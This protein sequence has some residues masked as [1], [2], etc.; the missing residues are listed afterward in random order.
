VTS[1]LGRRSVLSTLN[2][3]RLSLRTSTTASGPMLHLE[4]SDIDLADTARELT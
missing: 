2:L 4:L 1:D 3:L